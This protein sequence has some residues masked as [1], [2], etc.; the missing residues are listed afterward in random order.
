MI[1]QLRRL[2]SVSQHCVSCQRMPETHDSEEI[3]TLSVGKSKTLLANRESGTC[4]DLVSNG[5]ATG[6]GLL[7]EAYA[8]SG[9][10][11]IYQR[12]NA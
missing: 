7:I 8:H 1:E 10:N 2:Q 12:T 11:S 4:G 3:L 9:L 6:G 5:G